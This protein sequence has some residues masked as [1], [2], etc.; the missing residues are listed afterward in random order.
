MMEQLRIWLFGV[1]AAAMVSAILYTLLP[2]GA[3]ASIAKI[4]GG[5]ILLLVLV[6]PILQVDIGSLELRY[7]EYAA[8]IDEQ[9]GQY[10]AD[11]QQQLQQIIERESAAYISEKA[12]VFGLACTVQVE[13]R[14]EGDVPIPD[15]V[16]MDIPKH[17]EL[18]RWIEQELGIDAT[19]QYWREDE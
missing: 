15:D 1:I 5:L 12:A 19:H 6:R 13:C 9:I 16:T 7:D 18:S 17:M 14:W 10:R 11:N 8:Q 4:T 2:K 3:V